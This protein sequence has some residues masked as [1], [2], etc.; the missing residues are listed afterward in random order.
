MKTKLFAGFVGLQVLLLLA[1]SVYHTVL[2][3]TGEII[4]LE[5]EPVDPQDIFYGDYVT[6]RYEVESVPAEKWMSEQQ[7][8]R[9]E[10]V[11]VLLEENEDGIY[12]LVSAA[13]NKPEPSGNQVVMAGKLEYYSDFQDVYEL[14]FGIRRYF[15]EDNTGGQFENRSG[16]MTVTVAVSSW[17]PKR[18]L[19]I[20]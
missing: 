17:G 20:E 4:R 8:D 10:K 6:L 7:P 5:T 11:F 3:E 14:D 12:D 13:L 1:M 9:N 19:S 15:I 2:G 16:N 18:I